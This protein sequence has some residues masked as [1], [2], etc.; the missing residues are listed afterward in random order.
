MDRCGS[1]Q[2][3]IPCAKME[4]STFI[5]QY[6]DLKK[7]IDPVIQRN[8]YF[9]HPKNLLLTMI[10]DDRITI[11]KLGIRCILKARKYKKD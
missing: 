5:G 7:V 8:A 1:I 2:R 9:I 6:N 3:L 4:H 10:T 11:R